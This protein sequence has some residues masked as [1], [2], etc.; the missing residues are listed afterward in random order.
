MK[1][2]ILGMLMAACAMP[3]LAYNSNSNSN[4]GG[5][6][7]S[8]L[9]VDGYGNVNA[10]YYIQTCS[11][12]K[13]VGTS[14]LFGKYE[15][16]KKPYPELGRMHA[17]LQKVNGLKS[18]NKQFIY[19]SMKEAHEYQ[20]N[21][22]RSLAQNTMQIKRYEKMV[23]KYPETYKMQKERYQ[24]NRAQVIEQRKYNIEKTINDIRSQLDRVPPQHGN[25]GG[26]ATT[27]QTDWE[28]Y[29]ECKIWWTYEKEATETGQY[30]N[31]GRY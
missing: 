6:H 13:S 24:Q 20:Y 16:Y 31:Q 2:I 29:Q 22:Y 1:K 7:S 11:S 28:M 26:G 3:S 30:G 15:D 4:S 21:M 23:Q 17:E 27:G 18:D 10:G 12:Y 14:S 5:N 8:G 9:R 19:S 25:N